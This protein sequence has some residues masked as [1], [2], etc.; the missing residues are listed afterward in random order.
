MARK[1]Q[2]TPGPINLG[3]MDVLLELFQ[4]AP[5]HASVGL[6]SRRSPLKGQTEARLLC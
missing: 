2:P 4:E 5:L 3:G 1:S 6:E